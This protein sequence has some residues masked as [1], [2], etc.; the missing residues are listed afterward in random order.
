VQRLRDRVADVEM[1]WPMSKLSLPPIARRSM[2]SSPE[3]NDPARHGPH[4]TIFGA[5]SV[6]GYVRFQEAHTRHHCRQMPEV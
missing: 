4:R 5:V 1:L 6:E 2:I 3:G